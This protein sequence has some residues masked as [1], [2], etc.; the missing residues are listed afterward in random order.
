MVMKT[1]D[2]LKMKFIIFAPKGLK[3]G[4]PEGMHQL[5]WAI[6]SLGREAKLLAWPRTK[7]KSSVNEYEKY[8]P[9]WCRVSEINKKDIFIVSEGI[10]LLP[11]WYFLFIS[12]KRIYMWMHSVDFSL[13]KDLNQYERNNYPM[14][15]EWKIGEVTEPKIKLFIRRIGF[16]RVYHKVKYISNLL[17]KNA[18]KRRFKIPPSNYLF[19]SY[20]SLYTTAKVKNS[21]SDILLSGWVNGVEKESLEDI[22]F[23]KCTKNHVAFN[24]GKSKELVDR[25][26]EINV[27]QN[28][29]IHFM[30]IAGI[31]TDREVYKLLTSCDLYLDLGFFPGLERTP[32]EAIRMDCPVL[33]AK[34][35]AARFYEDFPLST[36]YLLDLYLLSPTQ[37]YD[38]II[39]ILSL[40]KENN[41]NNQKAFK[42]FV[43]SEKTTFLNE[44]KRFNDLIG[45]ING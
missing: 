21:R 34:R 43:L 23:C 30:P 33:L 9:R 36:N 15:S 3:T 44:V 22:Q 1:E 19:A 4:G 20:Y 27:S 14:N 11:F 32:R 40:G 10:R 45:K 17:K 38:K 41:L 13:D 26:I 8:G 24:P 6:N 39:N 35:G 31:K 18:F 7:R 42:D 25:I 16:L 2:S 5:A 12:R 37:T 29:I 28:Y